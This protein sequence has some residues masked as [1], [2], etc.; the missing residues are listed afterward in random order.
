MGC[1]DLPMKFGLRVTQVV[2]LNVFLHDGVFLL[3][4]GFGGLAVAVLAD[5]ALAASVWEVGGEE[6]TLEN[7]SVVFSSSHGVV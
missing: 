1:F 6:G 5:I 3:Q 7:P 2:D 4:P